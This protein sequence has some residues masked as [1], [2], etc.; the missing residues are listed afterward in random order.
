MGRPENVNCSS[1]S[2]KKVAQQLLHGEDK[3]RNV[4]RTLCSIIKG[5]TV[6]V[7]C[8]VKSPLAF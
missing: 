4:V 3:A 2:G 6:S 7:M 8:C 5:T 1:G